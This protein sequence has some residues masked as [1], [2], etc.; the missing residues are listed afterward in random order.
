MLLVGN[1]AR[2]P[3]PYE[4]FGSGISPDNI[5]K[6]LYAYRSAIAHG[7]SADFG[8][9]QFQA[10]RSAKIALSFVRRATAVVIRQKF[11]EPELLVDLREC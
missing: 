8:S 9:G 5:W 6:K 1:R 2:L 7:L 10:L 4:L 3:I 11:E